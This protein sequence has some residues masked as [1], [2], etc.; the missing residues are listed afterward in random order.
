MLSKLS[1]KKPYTVVVGVVLILILGYVSFTEMTTDLLP[2]IDFPYAVVMTPYV[3]AS[4]EEVEE[5]VTRPIEQ[6]MATINNI[7]NIT[8]TSS[9]NVSVVMLEFDDSVNMDSISIDMREKIDAVAANWPDEVGASTIMKINPDMLPIL[10]T[11]V[12]VD[13]MSASELSS[14]VEDK[15]IPSLESIEGVASVSDQ[16]ILEETVNVV[17]SQSK[18]DEVNAKL[19]EAVS[20]KLEEAGDALDE[21]SEELETSKSELTTKTE[22]F[23]EGI[24]TGESSLEEATE[25]LVKSEILLEASESSLEEKESMLKVLKS[26][27]SEL[28]TALDE[29]EK[30]LDTDGAKAAKKAL[31]T[32]IADAKTSLSE[33]TK[34]LTEAENNQAAIKKQID[35][36]VSN[37]TMT[38]EEKNTSL[39]QLNTSLEEAAKAVKE[40]ETNKSAL[41]TQ[42]SSLEASLKLTTGQDSILSTLNSEITSLKSQITAAEK[43]ISAGKKEITAAKAKITDGKALLKEKEKELY[44]QKNTGST[45]LHDANH[46]LQDGEEA[47]NEQKEQFEQ[48]KEEALKNADVK[49]VLTSELLTNI[50]TAQNFSMPAGYI[51]EEGIDYLVRVGDKVESLEELQNLVL[52]D[53]QVEGVDP[54]K[55][56]DVADVFI[57]DNSA[58][59]YAKVNGNEAVILSMQKQTNYATAEVCNKVKARFDSLKEE[60]NGLHATYLMDQGMY[61]DMVVDSV[62]SN[63]IFGGILAIMILYI[64]LRDIRPTFIIACSIPISVMFAIVLMYFSGVT[65]NIISLSGLAVGVGMLVDNSVVVIENIYRLRSKGVSVIKAAVSGAVQVSGAIIASTLTT[66]CVFL[67]IVFVKGITRQLFIDMALTIGYSLTASLIIALTL[68]PMMSAGMLKKTKEKKHPIFDKIVAGYEF[69]LEKALRFKVVVILLAVVLLIV[70]VLG[71]ISKGFE[72]MPEMDSTQI[73]VSM[74]MPEGAMFDDTV[75]MSNTV[76]D[77]IKKIDDV[78]TVGAMMSS[79]SMLSTSTST[80]AVTMYVMLKEDKKHT[81]QSIAKTIEEMCKEYDCDVSANGSSM[82]MSAL[83]GSGIAI[84]VRGNDLDTLKQTANEVAEIVS[85]VEGTKEVSNGI[86]DPATEL[87]ITVDKNKAMAEGLTVASAYLQINQAISGSKQATTL[88]LADGSEYPVMILKEESEELTTQEIK[89][90]VF[91][92]TTQNGE[93]KELLISD[94]ATVSMEDGFSTIQREA[95]QRYLTVSAVIEDGYNVSL[96]TQAVESALKDYQIPAGYEVVFEGENETIMESFEQLL[97]MLVL[98]IICIYLIMVAQFQSLLSPFIVLFTIPLAFTGGFLGLLL[99]GKVL[100]VIAMIGFVMLAGIIVNNGIVL[101]DYINQLRLDGVDKK[102]AILEAGKTRLRPILMTALTTILGLSTMALGIGSGADMVQPI[103]IVTIGGLVYATLMTLFVVPVLY[104]IFNRRK[105]KAVSEE[106]LEVVED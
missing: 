91:T 50:L 81:S 44:D 99:T 95:Q 77:T 75:E 9:E 5:S 16:G 71:S 15:V 25:E 90:Y 13:G 100:S 35:D 104:D 11:A 103:A 29:A 7:K 68:V 83:G 89:D 47:L 8:S 17:L 87:R 72:Y 52:F 3:G 79:G 22:E 26:T 92:A 39:E 33:L 24:Y 59:T 23:Y 48:Q 94:I 66:I 51:T 86:Q 84:Q 82:D 14:Y 28:E 10:V 69:L 2:S 46:Q 80:D 67:P 12:D 36:L 31:E 61:I 105:M 56:S 57:V 98:G 101:V 85:N 21:A 62:L 88:S 6:S 41:E 65:L 70:S 93:S 53:M 40:L 63:L 32:S 37:S 1:V 106:E 96:V 38:E 74:Q 55:L 54:I 27:L 73:T 58:E 20:K 34:L 42:I 30:A 19:K 43:T 4:P 45:Q 102:E 78:D 49:A 64:F 60:V 97:K 76:I 18:I